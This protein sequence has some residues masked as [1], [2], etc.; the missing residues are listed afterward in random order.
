M[1]TGH[2]AITTACGCSR[3]PVASFSRGRPERTSTISIS[4]SDLLRCGRRSCLAGRLG[5]S[6][7][8]ETAIFG[9]LTSNASWP[10]GSV[11]QGARALV[12]VLAESGVDHIFKLPGDTE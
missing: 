6:P 12:E 5:R 1:Q 4:A 10:G 2:S 7:A 9:V 11:M 3:P 8:A